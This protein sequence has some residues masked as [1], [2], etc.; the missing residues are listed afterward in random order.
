MKRAFSIIVMLSMIA[1]LSRGATDDTLQKYDFPTVDLLPE[2]DI[3]PNPFR[4]ADGNL[5]ETTG[6]WEQQRER[7]KAMLQHY[8]YGHQPPPP[9]NLKV[10]ELS[11]ESVYDGEATFKGLLFSMGPGQKVRFRASM[12]IPKG[13]GPFPVIIKNDGGRGRVLTPESGESPTAR[14]IASRGYILIK[15]A[16]TELDDDKA[17][18][19]GPAEAQFPDYDWGTIAM[20]AWGSSRI[21]DH[22]ET[23]DIADL[24][25]IV[26]TG[27]SRGG[28]AALC[29]GI[30][31]DRIAL[32][33]PNGSGCGGAGCFRIRGPAPNNGKA[34]GLGFRGGQKGMVYEFPHWFHPRL[35]TFSEKEDQLPFDLHFL[36]AVI[37]PRAVISIDGLTDHWANPVGTQ[38][39]YEGA[40]P[41]FEF[42]GVPEKLG[43]YYRDGG[44]GQTADDW[45]TLMDFADFIFFDKKPGSG[46]RFDQV[47][48]PN[49]SPAFNWEAPVSHSNDG[50]SR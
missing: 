16:R 20:W 28:K 19:K 50:I 27:H 30:F 34:Q 37:A 21:I 9:D 3:L 24:E 42:L 39:T 7:I 36:R 45:G 10:E 31:D 13:D 26:V 49:L 33:V 48:F 17:D 2:V 47:P 32:T 11:S 12:L 22:L 29:A 43:I 15:Y 6:E 41:V 46:K 25:K 4:K 23:L 1:L 40:K 18:T 38:V 8:M 44:H 35:Q 5:L 14:T